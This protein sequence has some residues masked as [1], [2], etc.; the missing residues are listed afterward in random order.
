VVEYSENK[1]LR[2]GMKLIILAIILTGIFFAAY[3]SGM[4][5]EYCGKDQDCFSENAKSCSPSEVYLS[6]SNNVY[7]Y[8]LTPIIGNKCN[9]K[10]TFERAQ[11]GLPPEHIE[12]LEGKSMNCNI[13]KSVLREKDLLKMDEIMPYCSGELKEALYELIVK[14]MYELIILNLGEIAEEAKNI[15]KM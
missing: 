5:R 7:H 1:K 3:Y 13:P 4:T 11:E 6:R 12:L 10:I 15:M 14:R 9:L 8:K 2:S